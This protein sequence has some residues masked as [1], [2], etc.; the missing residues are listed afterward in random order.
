MNPIMGIKLMNG[1]EIVARVSTRG[2]ALVLERPHVL[3]AVQTPS[4]PVLGLT[5]WLITPSDAGRGALDLSINAIMV[6]PY[7]VA[8]EVETDYIK[9]TSGIVL[10]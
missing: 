10:A 9:Q 8:P 6:M 1:E 2:N 5:P 4:G 3:R 7:G